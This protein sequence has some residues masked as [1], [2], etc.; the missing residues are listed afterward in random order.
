MAELSSSKGITHVLRTPGW[1]IVH[2]R[3]QSA[4]PDDQDKGGL[5]RREK[6]SK[7]PL[8]P[9]PSEETAPEEAMPDDTERSVKKG[10]KIDIQA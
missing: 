10:R 5:P 1:K 7:S 2:R 6:K 8:T 4:R 3:E 9:L